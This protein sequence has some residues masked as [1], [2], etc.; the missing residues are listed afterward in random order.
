MTVFAKERLATAALGAKREWLVNCRRWKEHGA[1]RGNE[2]THI[3][4]LWIYVMFGSERRL[5]FFCSVLKNAKI[6]FIMQKKCFRVLASHPVPH[7]SSQQFERTIEV[8]RSK[9]KWIEFH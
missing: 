3:L 1:I 6:Q 2:G 5:R 7:R 9:W 8:V 4:T